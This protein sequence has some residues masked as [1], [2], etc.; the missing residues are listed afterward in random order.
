M[1]PPT[2]CQ[3]GGFVGGVLASYIHRSVIMLLCPVGYPVNACAL[4]QVPCCEPPLI[5]PAEPLVMLVHLN[6]GDI[7]SRCP[8]LES[9]C[10]AP[11]TAAPRIDLACHTLPLLSRFHMSSMGSGGRRTPTARE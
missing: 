6:P 4:Y 3:C 9:Y 7:E 2:T 5:P 11:F 1:Y 10:L 8:C